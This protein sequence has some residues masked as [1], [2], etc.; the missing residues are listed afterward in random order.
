LDESRQERKKYQEQTE[1]DSKHIQDLTRQCKEMERILMRKHPDSVSALIVASKNSGS[2]SSDDTASANTRKLLELRISQ[3]ENDALEQDRKSQTILANVQSRFNSVQS[4]YETHIGDLETQ[5]LSLQ[6]INAKLG[7]KVIRKTDEVNRLQNL[8]ANVGVINSGT[9]TEDVAERDLGETQSNS[10]DRAVQTDPMKP[11]S[12]T[13]TN[14]NRS[15]TKKSLQTQHSNRLTHSESSLQGD[16]H[17]MATIRGM[18]LDLAIKEKAVQRLTRELDECKK[19][20]KKLQKENKDGVQKSSTSS[21]VVTPSRK[22]Y[23]SAQYTDSHDTQAL[24]DAQ[25]RIRFL[26][27]DYKVLHEKR[28]SDVRAGKFHVYRRDIISFVLSVENSTSCP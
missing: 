28:L 12:A 16:A 17:L 6:D 11:S 27:K 5:V 22:V 13:S 1:K 9:Q 4:K 3:L 15:T 2:P 19:T 10:C 21:T 26:E 14:S 24:K 18:R 8:K 7:E 25:S 20:I 23:D